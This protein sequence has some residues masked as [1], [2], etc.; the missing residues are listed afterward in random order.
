MT[1]LDNIYTVFMNMS[2]CCYQLFKSDNIN[3]RKE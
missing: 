2:H 3:Y 1:Q